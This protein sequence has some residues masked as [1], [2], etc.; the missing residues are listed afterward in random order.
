MRSRPYVCLKRLLGENGNNE[1]DEIM[2]RNNWRHFRNG[3]RHES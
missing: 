3:I 1:E 2:E